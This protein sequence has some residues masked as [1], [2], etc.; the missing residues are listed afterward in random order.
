[1]WFRVIE[2]VVRPVV[3]SIVIVLIEE[4]DNVDDGLWVLLLF[5]FCDTICLK[6]A[7]PFPGETLLSAVS[8]LLHKP[9][10]GDHKQA[11]SIEILNI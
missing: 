11:L 6:R 2:L 1:M 3:A 7:L 5:L 4:R 8:K 10:L 9:H